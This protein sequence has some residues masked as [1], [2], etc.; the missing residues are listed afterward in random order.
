MN[1]AISPFRRGAD[2]GFKFGA[3]LIALYATLVAGNSVPFLGLISFA[4]MAGVPGVTYMLL[5]RDH[6]LPE[7]PK[8]VG[9]LW[10]DGLIMFFGGALLAGALL[11][12][13][14][15]WIDPDYIMDSIRTTVDLLEQSPD[16]D[17][18]QTA[19]QFRTAMDNGFSISPVI[20]SMTLVWMTATSGSVL[21]LIIATVIVHK[22]R[23]KNK[24]IN[25]TPPQI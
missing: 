8:T 12:A 22:R 1:E 20:F 3:Y 4:L 5:R 25:N 19:E 15:S 13:Y 10:I 23:N 24:P 11:T 2:N 7:G 6:M 14:L 17:S 16:S 9:A 18:Q 21:S